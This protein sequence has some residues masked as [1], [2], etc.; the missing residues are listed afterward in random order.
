MPHYCYCLCSSELVLT[1]F[2]SLGTDAS[3]SQP[4]RHG[5]SKAN[6]DV[7]P[8]LLLVWPPGLEIPIIIG[9][10]LNSPVSC[11]TER[12]PSHT[13]VMYVLQQVSVSPVIY[14]WTPITQWIVRVVPL[15]PPTVPGL[16]NFMP[17]FGKFGKIPTGNPGS[18]PALYFLRSK[19]ILHFLD[20]RYKLQSKDWQCN[21]A[22]VHS[23]WITQSHYSSP[24]C[25]VDFNGYTIQFPD[26]NNTSYHNLEH[27]LIIMSNNFN[28]L[29]NNTYALLEFWI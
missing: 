18:A 23:I 9:I 28:P 15:A 20:F 4:S 5:W 16:V 22:L 12:K 29:S 6:A 1:R 10:W 19:H 21:K 11:P 17:F 27:R 14:S 7:R 13:K 24:K 25:R 3:H 26:F 8:T 2:I